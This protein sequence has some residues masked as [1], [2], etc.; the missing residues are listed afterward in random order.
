MI[1]SRQCLVVTLVAQYIEIF[2]YVDLEWPKQVDPPITT[3]HSIL[4]VSKLTILMGKMITG[5]VSLLYVHMDL[6]GYD[7]ALN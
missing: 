5:M 1:I 6:R 2:F 3:W 7:S 4:T